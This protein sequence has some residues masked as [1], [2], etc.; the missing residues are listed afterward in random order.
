[1]GSEIQIT[2]SGCDVNL[3]ELVGSGFT[4]HEYLVC[5]CD[6][7]K[8]FVNREHSE[9]LRGEVRAKFRCGKCRK[10]LRIIAPIEN[11][12]GDTDGPLGQCPKCGGNL[13]ASDTG[14]MWD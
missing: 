5:V 13:S 12:F 10:P 6:Y 7:C 3:T 11:E 2:C 1:M 14:L 4:G 8:S 9:I